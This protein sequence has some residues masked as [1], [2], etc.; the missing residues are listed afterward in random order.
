MGIAAA[1]KWLEL[2]EK[3]VGKNSCV[4]HKVK[5]QFNRHSSTKL[6][7]IQYCSTVSKA[8]RTLKL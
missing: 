8:A 4:D 1:G 6:K 5:E 2:S 3:V 7:I